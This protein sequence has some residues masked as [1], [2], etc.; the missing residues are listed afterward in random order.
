MENLK[1]PCAP[2][3][4]YRSYSRIIE[5]RRENFYDTLHRC[6]EGLSILGKLNSEEKLL[7]LRLFKELKCLPSGR[8]LW[9]GG[10]KWIENPKNFSGAYNCTSLIF[11]SPKI[12]G[13]LMDLSMQG[14][15]TGSIIEKHFIENIPKIKNKINLSI[16]NKIG[17]LPKNLRREN[18]EIIEKDLGKFYIQLGDSREGWIQGYQGLIDLSMKADYPIN[19]IDIELDLGSIRS[20]G[21]KLKSFGG[22]ANPEGLEN[23]FY[24]IADILNANINKKLNSLQIC[25]LIDEASKCVV[26]GNIRRSAGIHQGSADDEIFIN[27]KANLWQKIGDKWRIDPER[28]SLRMAN[29]TIVFHKKP[30]YE[31]ILKSIE[32]QYYSGEGA[33][34][35][36]GEAIARANI[37]L[38]KDKKDKKEF[39]KIYE[40]DRDKA[41]DFLRNKYFSIYNEEISEK[42]LHHRIL[43]YGLNPCGEIIGTN[44]HCNLSEIHLNNLDPKNFD[45]QEEAFRAGT[46]AAA[47]LLHHKFINPLYQESREFDPIV[48]VSITGLFDFFVK[49]FGIDWIIWWQEGSPYK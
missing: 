45:E 40:E 41:K 21:E 35:W 22:I 12:F 33:I 13:Y 14:C 34:Q 4:F 30:S 16:S 49:T 19:N 11:D 38:I 37:D 27:A 24:R 8:W 26:S 20:K 23:L 15:G 46:L 31:E 9:I 29:H 17:T 25:L 43:R 28:D 5:N 48:G 42:E 47:S 2:L 39:L 32:S 3:I 1:A 18:T 44:F 7:L 10:S 6:I 36:A